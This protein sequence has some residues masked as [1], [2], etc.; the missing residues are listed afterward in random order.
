MCVFVC[1]D[2]GSRMTRSTIMETSYT[3]KFDSQSF[4]S[5]STVNFKNFQPSVNLILNISS[6]TFLLFFFCSFVSF[7]GGPC[8]PSPSATPH[9]P[10]AQ[11]RRSEGQLRPH[12]DPSAHFTLTL[13]SDLTDGECHFCLSACLIVRTTRR[14]SADKRI[15][16]RNS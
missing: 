4:V 11:A 6:F 14:W 5:V 13:Q 8:R 3:Q 2:D 1:V 15:V 12:A 16:E 10:P 9:L 7:Q